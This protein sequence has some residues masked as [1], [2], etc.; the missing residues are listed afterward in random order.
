VEEASPHAETSFQ[1]SSFPA[2]RWRGRGHELPGCS[3][4]VRGGGLDGCE[5]G[6]ALARYGCGGSA[7]PR[8][9][10]AVG[11]IEAHASEILAL[12]AGKVDMTLM[13]IADHLACAHGERFAQST[14]WRFLDRH[15]QT[16]KKNH[17]RQRTGAPGR[18]ARQAGLAQDA[19]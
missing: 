16:F 18:G 3:D 15:D 17:S 10:Q 7:A 1:R 14:V 6:A 8:W 9:R 2:D 13:E 12:I 5:V 11:R 19:A 4:P